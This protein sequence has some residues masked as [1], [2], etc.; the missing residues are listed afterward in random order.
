MKLKYTLLSLACAATVGSSAQT[1][2]V[3]SV[4]LNA[5]YA[6]DAYY[7]LAN[8]NTK[9][10]TADDW[11][12][13]F[14]MSKFGATSFNASVRAN[15]IKGK[16]QVY[17]IGAKASTKFGNLVASDT[18]GKVSPATQLVNNDTSW[19]E[20]A[21]TVNR[22]T[23]SPVDFGWAKYNMT[24]H[25]LSGDSLYIVMIDG[26]AYQLHLQEYK[27][28]A[29]NEMYKFRFAKFDG[30]GLV[31]DSIKRASPYTDRLFAYYNMTTATVIDR[32]PSIGAWD[33]LFKQY[34]KNRTFGPVPGQ[35]QAYTGVLANLDVEI[36]EV[37]SVDPNN[38]TSSNFTSHLSNLKKETNTIGDNWKTFDMSIFKYRVHADTSYI[39]KSKN[40]SSYYHI[41]FT[42]FD[43]TAT[44]KIVFQ[45][46]ALGTTSVASV[47]NNVSEY[48]IYP[49]PANNQVNIMIDA[50]A[51]A[52]NA[53]IVV[54]D[55]TGKVMMTTTA[56]MKKGLNA[57]QFDVTNY[58]SGTYLVVVS[59][60]GWKIAD[61][62]MVQ[63]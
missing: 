33:L 13:A 31:E 45:K 23:S 47:T 51:Q 2:V 14:Q 19:G 52:N 44:G 61:K 34:Q 3:D 53:Q 40:N 30:S 41:Q 50:R 17:S 12:I 5:G 42:R 6:K 21:F 9:T 36:A 11:H 7:N 29:N 60:G 8:G 24:T 54:T 57:Y 62:I 27:S 58:P 20:G 16:V 39:V 25:N 18:M 38:L 22:N 28:A 1:W 4:D 43:G 26:A 59:N 35:L 46:R 49:N 32:E 48:S 15:H 10:Q 37:F 63:H 56:N 55:I